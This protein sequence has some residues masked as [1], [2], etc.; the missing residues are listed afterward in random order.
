MRIILDGMGGDHA[1]ASVV[2]GAVLASKQIE[3]EIHII[4]QEEL[5][6]AE[7]AK[8]K[9]DAGKIFVIDAREVIT[10][11]DALNEFI[12]VVA[13]AVASSLVYCA[14]VQEEPNLYGKINVL[15]RVN[16][17]PYSPSSSSSTTSQPK[18]PAVQLGYFCNNTFVVEA[19][20]SPVLRIS[21]IS[22]SFSLIFSGIKM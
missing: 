14:P 7:L 17:N 9:Y 19:E 15:L 22:R 10:N 2:E 16:L 6:H 11:D 8:Y 18:P 13:I 21:L 1:P 5:I 20:E 3:H 12:I 4:G